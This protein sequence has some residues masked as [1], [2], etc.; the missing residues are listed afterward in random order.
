[1]AEVVV[2]ALA[3]LGAHE[4]VVVGPLP[5]TG[6]PNGSKPGA[7]TTRWLVR[8]R[9][10]RPASHRTSRPTRGRCRV[11]PQ[12]ASRTQEGPLR[13]SET[14]PDRWPGRT[15]GSSPP[16]NGTAGAWVRRALRG[17]SGQ[18]TREAPDLTARCGRRSVR[19]AGGSG[20][21]TVMNAPRR[22]SRPRPRGP[23]PTALRGG[24]MPSNS[25]SIGCSGVISSPDL[26]L[27]A[28]TTNP[29]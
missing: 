19:H 4:R 15:A 10:H 1:M 14:P 5:A 20:T 13:S 28:S 25:P 16:S 27:R 24:L 6:S 3:T 7:K 12:P 23:G 11:C 2:A 9:N 18:N 17:F 22:A 8:V 26:D 29:R 21:C